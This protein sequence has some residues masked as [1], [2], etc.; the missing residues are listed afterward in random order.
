MGNSD[1]TTV[2]TNSFEAPVIGDAIRVKPTEWQGVIHIA[3]E[4]LGSPVPV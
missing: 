4:I 3:M 1:A 2:V